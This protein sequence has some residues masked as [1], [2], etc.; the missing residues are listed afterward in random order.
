MGD[1]MEGRVLFVETM[2]WGSFS[3]DTSI[4]DLV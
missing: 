4:F 3:S 2:A 1:G